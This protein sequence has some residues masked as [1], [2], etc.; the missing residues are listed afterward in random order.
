[1]NT[2]TYQGATLNPGCDLSQLEDWLVEAL[3]D[4]RFLDTLHVKP[5]KSAG[6]D[7]AL[8]RIALA[9]CPAAF[10][11]ASFNAMG[12][13][14]KAPLDTTETDVLDFWC[15]DDPVRTR[16]VLGF[17]QLG[18]S[19][20]APVAMDY[21]AYRDPSWRFVIV[22]SSEG[23]ACE[24]LRRMRHIIRAAWWLQ[25]L[26]PTEDDKDNDTELQ[27]GCAPKGDQSSVM[28]IGITGTL[29]SK[30]AHVVYGDDLEQPT[31]TLTVDARNRLHELTRQFSAWLYE[32][33][34]SK[35]TSPTRIL[36]SGTY[37]A[38]DSLYLRQVSMDKAAARAYPVRYPHPTEKIPYLAPFL[39]E[40][41]A[42]ERTL[43]GSPTTPRRFGIGYVAEQEAK[44]KLYFHW[45]YLML[46]GIGEGERR[47]LKLGDLMVMPLHR[48]AV[49]FPVLWGEHDHNGSTAIGTIENRSPDPQSRLQAIRRPAQIGSTT[50][51]YQGTKAGLDIAGAGADRMVLCIVSMAA[52]TFFV[53]NLTIMS[54]GLD[55]GSLAKIAAALREHGATELI[56]EKNADP[57]GAFGQL[58]TKAIGD[59]AVPKGADPLYPDGWSCQ[60]TG[61]HSSGQKELRV[62][63]TIEPLLAGHKIVVAPQVLEPQCPGHPEH[64]FQWQFTRITRERNSLQHDDA[65]DAMQIALAAWTDSNQSLSMREDAIAANA[66]KHKAEE[67][68]DRMKRFDQMAIGK[69]KPEAYYTPVWSGE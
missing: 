13:Q 58:L 24:N 16:I 11:I 33:K 57:T 19:H 52:A 44:S 25:H 10:A 5:K 55:S 1:M 50:I 35:N 46:P 23:L 40:N 27:F 29:A 38:E 69:K 39:A 66:A 65:V 51:N 9:Q 48:D 42:K 60:V 45:Q 22:A 64:E 7:A 18:K 6:E 49:P 53:K 34:G 14:R 63:N 21:L 31:N 2:L 62:I 36:E 41:L 59:A 56:Y 68:A 3:R 30:R 47:P 15:N 32:T 28:A 4:E 12:W 26:Q 43:A 54:G 61:K 67:W 8:R 17:R 20:I 37:H